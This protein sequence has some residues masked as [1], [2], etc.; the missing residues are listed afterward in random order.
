MLK[1]FELSADNCGNHNNN[2]QKNQGWMEK[3][4]CIKR[5]VFE[6]ETI[7]NGKFREGIL[8]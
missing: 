4:K 7:G 5:K 6:V 8:K 1:S 2:L 3:R